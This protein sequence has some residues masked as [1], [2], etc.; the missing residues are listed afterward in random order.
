MKKLLL[1][2]IFLFFAWCPCYAQESQFLEDISGVFKIQGDDVSQNGNVLV[3][4]N[5]SVFMDGMGNGTVGLIEIGDESEGQVGSL[6][7]RDIA[8]PG[9]SV[10][11]MNISDMKGNFSAIA[12]VL[13]L[14]FQFQILALTDPDEIEK[15]LPVLKALMPA[16]K[17]FQIGQARMT[18]LMLGENGSELSIKNLE[19]NK[20]KGIT[21]WG[22][23]KIEDV[24]IRANQQLVC[25]I[26]ELGWEE[27]AYGGLETLLQLKS[28]D[29]QMDA[30][31][32][33][34]IRP[35]LDI[36]LKNGFIK[37]LRIPLVGA[38]ISES[39]LNI[40]SG[41]GNLNLSWNLN[42]LRLPG[43]LL[44]LAQIENG[45]DI[46]SI[47]GD[48]RIKSEYD[49]KNLAAIQKF[50][51]TATDLFTI[52]GQGGLDYDF[53]LKQDNFTIT[54]ANIIFQNK[55][56]A[57]CLSE[58]MKNQIQAAVASTFPPVTNVVRK[59][60][61]GQANTIAIS[62]EDSTNLE[63]LSIEVK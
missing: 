12:P 37:N 19:Y 53:T 9:L 15:S 56:I 39:K 57:S 60:L 8:F 59:L 52:S 62:L 3:L 38:T 55:G 63:N 32:F 47:N 28:Q 26:V 13:P 29:L 17:K 43:M 10:Q 4:R 44:A 30:G 33:Q 42:D 34:K 51:F 11:N 25:S 16:L 46:V 18:G 23:G 35:L 31:S 2:L 27:N 49:E 54:N 7:M 48:L 50:S 14:M 24:R 6:V 58:N 20:I 21:S 61:S 40:N 41:D 36:T 1:F 45:P 22:P 5:C